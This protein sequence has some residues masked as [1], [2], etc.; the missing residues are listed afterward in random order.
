MRSVTENSIA[1]FTIEMECGL[2]ACGTGQAR[3]GKI[4]II[5]SLLKK[6]DVF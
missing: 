2:G 1:G 4:V 6:F 5:L 3:N